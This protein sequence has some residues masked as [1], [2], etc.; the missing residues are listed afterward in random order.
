MFHGV[1]ILGRESRADRRELRARLRERHSRAQTRDRVVVRPR[2][3]ARVRRA[4]NARRP[5]ES[6]LRKREAVGDDADNRPRNGVEN[7]LGADD[8]G[9]RGE[10]IPPEVLGNHDHV[11]RVRRGV[12]GRDRPTEHGGDAEHLEHRGSDQRAGDDLRVLGAAKDGAPVGDEGD[13]DERPGF[14]ADS[15]VIAFRQSPARVAVAAGALRQM[16][17]L[18]GS[19]EREIGRRHG[20]LDGE[21]RG[22]RANAEGERDDRRRGESGTRAQLAHGVTKVLREIVEQAQADRIARVVLVPL[23]SA[24]RRSSQTA[25][26]VGGH[27]A[28]N[29]LGGFH[30][31]VEAHLVVHVALALLSAG[32]ATG[33]CAKESCRLE[34]LLDGERESP[35]VGAFAGELLSSGGGERIELRAASLTR[36]APLGANQSALFEAIEGRIER[37]LIDLENVA[38]TSRGCVW[39]RPNRGADRRGGS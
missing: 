11:A 21:Y 4:E 2:A 7:D 10:A 17:Q 22:R 36:R 30:F 29:E 8:A 34:D 9:V 39:T 23:D 24:E 19:S 18:V 37:A 27:A 31:D 26:F 13:A 28:A 14:V 12:R 25:G 15:H 16:D 32:R 1:R 33:A 38:R 3:I 20:T 5:D 6:S 35:P